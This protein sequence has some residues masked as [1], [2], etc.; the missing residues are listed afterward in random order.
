[1]TLLQLPFSKGGEDKPVLFCVVCRSETDPSS[2]VGHP[3]HGGHSHLYSHHL[4]PGLRPPRTADA[5]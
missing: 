2:L 4:F 3:N 5:S 1:A